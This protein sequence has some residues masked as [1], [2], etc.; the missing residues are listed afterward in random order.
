VS[1]DTRARR[2]GR[3]VVVTIV[4]GLALMWIYVLFVV[5][6]DSATT[7]ELHDST[8]AKAAQPVCAATLD[9]LHRLDVVNKVAATPQDRATLVDRADSSL[10]RMVSQ[11]RTLPVPNAD[12]ATAVSKWLD[13]WDQWL[14]DRAAWSDKLRRGEDAPFVEKERV[15]THQPNS[16]ALND[17]ALVNDMRAC[18]TPGGI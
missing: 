8:F 2:V 11:L 15:E 4:L 5:N 10:T 3:V 16:K 17:F 6:G 13:D 18:A 7:D 12:D 14:R 1:D 9:E